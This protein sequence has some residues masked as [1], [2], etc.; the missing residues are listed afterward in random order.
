MPDPT[1]T[2][3]PT[4]SPTPTPDPTP[5]PAWHAGVDADIL[6]HWQN[7]GWKID[8]PKEIALAATK[9]ARE[10]EK[11]FG[12]P[13]D[14]LLKMP[15]A[16]A[17]PED[18]KA[19]YQRLGAP[20]DPKDYDFN[21]IK[22]NGEDLEAGFADTMRG[23][24]NAAYVSKDKAGPFVSGVVKWLEDADKAESAVGTAKLAEEKASLAKNWGT[25]YD[26]NH[27][28]AMEGARIAGVS[29]ETV[30]AMENVMGYAGV[31]EH[32]RRIGMTGSEDIFIERGATGG[33]NPTTR[34]G[35]M[36]RKAE[37]MADT[38]W[39]ERYTKG[40]QQEKREMDALNIMIDG[41]A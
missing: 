37:L 6:G 13:A 25:N 40:G 14:Q 17:K 15:K 35:A 30:K 24:L 28:K 39:G 29:P 11:H 16:D 2:P 10:A 3:T 32:F 18:I 4:P 8:D 22:F 21:G 26:F 33:G 1:P 12:V 36:A 23:L 19:F 20:A 38:A 27:L 7:K 41:A 31:M 9:Q 34:E 5:A